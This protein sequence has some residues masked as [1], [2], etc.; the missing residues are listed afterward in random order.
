MSQGTKTVQEILNEL[1]KSATWMIHPPDVYMFC[2]WFISALHDSLCNGV[3]KKGYN[4]EFSTID[5]L[6]ETAQMIEEAS[7]YHHGMRCVESTHTAVSNTKATAYKTQP[8]TGQ[9]RTIIGR[10]NIVHCMQTM[11]TYNAP[12]PEQKNVQVRDSSTKP[13]YRQKPLPQ[14]PK[15]EGNSMNFTCYECGQLGHI[16]TNCPHITKVRT[17]AVRADGTEDPEVDPQ[18][19]GDLPPDKEGEGEISEHQEEQLDECMGP[20][21]QWDTEE[22]EETDNNDVSYR[23]NAIRIALDKEE[24]VMTK[25]MA[26]QTKAM[27]LSKTVEPMC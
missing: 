21:Y 2:K 25:V 1:K 8:P 24:Q 18:E 5:Q 15:R 23:T 22:E 10:E 3:L 17:A 27:V 20:Q 19:E 26:V 12:K 11:C 13:S 6:Y 9:S 4:A 14:L 7:S 16:Q